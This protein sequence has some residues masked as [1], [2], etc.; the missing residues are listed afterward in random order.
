MVS[1]GHN[2]SD[3]G[4]CFLSG[5]LLDMA[6]TNAQLQALAGNGGPTE[7]MALVMNTP[8]VDAGDNANCPNGDQRG[9][10]RPADGNLKGSSM[11]DI[12]AYELFTPTNDLHSSGNR[13]QNRVRR[14]DPANASFDFTNDPNASADATGVVISTGAIPAAYSLTGSTVSMGGSTANCPFD[15]QTRVVTCDVGT[16][17]RG[18][19]AT[20]DLQGTGTVAGPLAITAHV[21]AAAPVDLFPDNNASTVTMLI[22]GNSNMAISASGPGQ[23]PT[24]NGSAPVSFTVKNLGPDDANNVRV[25]ARF[26]TRM[27]YQNMQMSNGASCTAG[28]DNANSTCNLGSIPAGQ[29]V[30]GT[31]NLQPTSAG[32]ATVELQVATDDVD[33][34]PSNDS[35][36]VPLTVAAEAVTPT[37]PIV[38]SSGGGGGCVSRP[39]GPFDPAL[40]L[41]VLA[42]GA[43]LVSRK[44]RER[45]KDGGR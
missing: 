31:L 42:G 17:P 5:S 18:Q 11:C 3:D 14:G 23:N 30:T 29:S 15:A 36:V 12:G 33:S 10:L 44:W 32:D 24:V 16:L 26:Q 35:V 37:T 28:Q 39:G 38:S 20:L 45:A 25:L 43:G 7:T 22:Q 40:L 41:L 2:L 13:A 4:T 19:T 27:R 1:Q 6:S 8:A 9:N 21:S 34:D